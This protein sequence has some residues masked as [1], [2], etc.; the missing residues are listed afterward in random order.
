MKGLIIHTNTYITGT[1]FI[2]DIVLLI[3]KKHKHV[4]G[5]NYK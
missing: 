3:K 4:N 2:T 1:Y 5:R